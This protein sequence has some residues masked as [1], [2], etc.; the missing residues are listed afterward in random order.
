VITQRMQLGEGS[1][2]T[3]MSNIYRAR[4]IPGFFQGYSKDVL[5]FITLFVDSSKQRLH[6]LFTLRRALVGG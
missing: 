1:L 4:G 5:R 2:P 6:F 3:V